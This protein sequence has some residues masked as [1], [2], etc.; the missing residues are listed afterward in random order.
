MH[1]RSPLEAAQLRTAL[2]MFSGTQCDGIF[3]W[4]IPSVPLNNYPLARYGLTVREL[5]DNV[6]YFMFWPRRPILSPA[7][8]TFGRTHWSTLLGMVDPKQSSCSSNVCRCS[9]SVCSLHYS[10]LYKRALGAN[11]GVVT[12]ALLECSTR[13]SYYMFDISSWTNS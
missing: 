13:R 4:V 1:Q 12:H 3:I 7:E 5:N 6:D 11:L 9:W 2:D 10:F 8:W